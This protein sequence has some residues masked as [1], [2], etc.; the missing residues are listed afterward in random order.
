MIIPDQSPSSSSP[1]TDALLR[2]L[3]VNMAHTNGL[4]LATLAA[5]NNNGNSSNNW[6]GSYAV[7]INALWFCSLIC[8]LAAASISILVKQ[9][10][11]QYTSGMASVSPEIA[12][13]RQFRY[14]SLRKWRVAEL[15]MLLPILLQSA[16]VLFLLGLILFLIQLNVKVAIAATTLIVVLLLFLF[17]T[18]L[19]PTFIPECPYQ[20]PQAWGVFVVFQAIKK[21]IRSIARSMSSYAKRFATP[22]AD[23]TWSRLRARLAK[24]FVKRITRFANKPNT[25]SWK[26]RER[27]LVESKG[28]ALDQHLLV[29]ADVTFLDDTFL[30]DVIRP[31]LNA[32]P[33]KEAAECYHEIMA[34]RADHV[35]NGVLYFA[36]QSTRPES[37]VVLTNLTLDT[38]QKT[39]AGVDPAP[40]EHTISIMSTLEPLLVRVLPLTY[41]HFCEVFFGLLADPDETVRHLAFT[42]LY[43]Q[44][45]RNPSL[46]EQYASSGCHGTLPPRHLQYCLAH[47]PPLLD[48][49]A[50]VAFMGRERAKGDVKYFLDA[51]DLVI[52]LA[53]LPSLSPSS[54]S[55]PLAPPVPLSTHAA[56]T[57]LLAT[58]EHLRAF[59]STPALWHDEP[60]LI[61]PLA[62][63]A[64]HLV[65]LERRR[66]RALSAGPGLGLL[67]ALVAVAGRAKVWNHDGN[68]EDKLIALETA[69]EELQAL[70]GVRGDSGKGKGKAEGQEEEK[71]RA[72]RR[73]SLMRSPAL[74]PLEC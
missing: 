7:A 37:V 72:G 46:A 43:A 57:P 52:Y 69:L 73:P 11:N 21:P 45:S 25:Y 41:S 56:D 29:G 58:L 36:P 64:P 23:G 47:P 68:L 31:C 15:M 71:G 70:C 65:M 10:L 17:V 60:R 19:L 12:R 6:P 32:M 33:P 63:I 13:V 2:L 5:N 30:R 51:C 40:V 18:A 42:I 27:N 20:S 66:P 8:S 38:L 61:Y 74:V 53:A 54:P 16:L 14:D 44:L 48:F 59:L 9:W 35:V 49:N 39:R 67:D 24:R 62:R 1:N 28:A 55:S 34:H 22:H 4:D 26:A 3:I 50:L